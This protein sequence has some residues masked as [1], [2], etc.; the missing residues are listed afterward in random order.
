MVGSKIVYLLI[1]ISLILLLIIKIITKK[2][3]LENFDN[4]IVFLD[5]KESCNLIKNIDYFMDLTE[6]DLYARKLIS[7]RNNIFNAY[8]NGFENFTNN[9]KNKLQTIVNSL[10]RNELFSRFS[11]AKIGPNIEYGYPHTHKDTIFMSENTIDRPLKD[12]IY[13]IVHE[14]MH[15]MQRKKSELFKNLYLDRL[16]FKQGKLIL[17]NKYKNLIRSNPDT[18]LVLENEFIYDDGNDNYYYLNAFFRKKQPNN[19]GD[20]EYLAIKCELT[21]KDNK[22]IFTTTDTTIKL[23]DFSNFNQF[24]GLMGN[25]YHPNEIS[26]ELIALHYSNKNNELSPALMIIGSWLKQKVVG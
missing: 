10:P 7:K 12:L 11:F 5:K 14:Q 24:F 9:E 25:H 13:V 19:L 16:K 3:T 22:N 4:K 1:V 17:D 18:R 6:S 26:A 23:E 8:C 2:N 21:E 20:V 15:V